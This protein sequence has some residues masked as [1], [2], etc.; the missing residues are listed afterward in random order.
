MFLDSIV[1]QLEFGTSDH[2]MLLISTDVEVGKTRQQNRNCIFR[3]EPYW[4]RDEKC[5]D[6][7]ASCWNELDPSCSV[8]ERLAWCGSKLKSWSRA[9]YGS[10]RKQIEQTK[11][12]IDDLFSRADEHGIM[13]QIK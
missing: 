1:S 12:T 4:L 8:A 10:L 7:V 9:K 11:K 2:R 3:F 13:D 5:F 6:L